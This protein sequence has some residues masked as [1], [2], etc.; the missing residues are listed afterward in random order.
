MAKVGQITSYDV[1]FYPTYEE[2]KHTEAKMN[3]VNEQTFYPTYEEWKRA[4]SPISPTKRLTFYPTY[5]EWK[6]PIWLYTSIRL[7]LF[8]LPMRN[9]NQ[10]IRYLQMRL[11][12]TFYPTYEEWKPST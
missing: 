9:G 8:I 12:Q 7:F 10:R 5:E 6:L 3:E 1:A 11:R 4:W 2:W